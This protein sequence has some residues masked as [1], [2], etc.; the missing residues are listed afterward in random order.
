MNATLPSPRD[1]ILPSPRNAPLP[2]PRDAT[3]PSPRSEP[4]ILVA[5]EDLTARRFLADNLCADGFD[6]LEANSAEAA[7][8]AMARK[9][10]D[11]VVL[12]AR[13][14]DADGLEVIRRVRGGDRVSSRIDPELPV[15]VLSRRDSELDR[16]RAF[17]RG[18]DDFLAVPYSYG[19]LRA[20]IE[21]VLRRARRGAPPVRLRV[22]E[23]VVDPASRSVWVGGTAVNLSKKEFSLLHTLAAEPVRVFTRAELLQIVWGFPGM[24]P[25]RTIDTHAQR[26]RHKLAAAGGRYV[27]NVWGV[28]YRLIDPQEL[29]TRA[30]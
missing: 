25:T 10:P 3:L 7:L 29:A 22:G 12:N 20:R 6:P 23:L 16:L 17:S 24:A 21:A 15:I 1:A 9:A 30:A 4:R 26:L 14:P 8:A 28:G 11:L 5:E 18:A 13:L 2:S 19:E 27:I